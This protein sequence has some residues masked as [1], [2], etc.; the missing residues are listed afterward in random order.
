MASGPCFAVA[1]ILQQNP[2]NSSFPLNEIKC[3]LRWLQRQFWG[4]VNKCALL[5]KPNWCRKIFQNHPEYLSRKL[6]CYW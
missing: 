5:E 6:D 3:S 2:V 1:G 4:M